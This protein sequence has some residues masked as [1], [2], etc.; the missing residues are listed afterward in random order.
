MAESYEQFKAG[1]I[2]MPVKSGF[3]IIAGKVDGTFHPMMRVVELK[4]QEGKPPLVLVV[5]S[6]DL[7][8]LI[9]DEELNGTEEILEL[10]SDLLMKA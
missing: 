4:R 7:E 10:P 3:T 9:N 5:H 8:H 6:G 1:V 2:V